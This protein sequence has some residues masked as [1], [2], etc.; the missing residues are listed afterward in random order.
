MFEFVHKHKRW[1][2][3][4]LLVLIVPPFALFGVD[5][6]FRNSDTSGALVTVGDS[7]ISDIEYSR[8][9]RQSQERMR[10]MMRDNP[11]PAMLNSP[12]FKESVLN[13]LVE[14]KVALA[15]AHGKGMS[16]SD[17]ELQKFIGAVEAF[18]DEKGQFSSERYRQLLRGQ[19]MS[20]A[21][22]EDQIRSNMLIDQVRSVYS[23]SGFVTDAVVERMYRIREQ[24]RQISQVLFSPEG[25]RA[26]VKAD[27][28]AIEKF[29][30]EQKAD[31]QI[32]ERVKVEY[33]MLSLSGL[34][35]EAVVTD[36]D[37]E[38]FYQA[39]LSR[40]QTAEERRASHIL[41]AASA[42]ASAAE[43]SAA[44][45]QAE[46]LLKQIKA[47][48]A[49]FAEL[50]G[51]FSKD[52]GSAEKGGD[53]GF[54][55]R[56]LMV[57]PF[58]DVAFSLKVGELAGPVETQY[59]YHLIR[60]DAIKPGTAEPLAKL[61]DQ[62]EVEIRKTGASRKFAEAADSF[63]NLVYE[64]FDSLQPAADALKLPV[65]K[66]DW[67]GRT[68]GNPNPLLNNDKLLAALF[69]DEVLK[70]KHNTPAVE[71]QPGIMLSARIFEHKPAEA[72][73]LD[74]VKEDI[75]QQLVEKEAAQLAEKEGRATLEKL[76]SG[77]SPKL[78][79]S[80]N[81]TVTLEK[82]QGLRPEDTEAIFGADVAKLPAYVSV[83]GPRGGLLIYR[84]AGIKDVTAVDP[85]QA[86]VLKRQLSQMVGQEQYIAVLASLRERANVQV[87]KKKLEQ[88][89]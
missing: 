87:D 21:E 49:K 57:K 31:F 37:I 11:N 5:F 89:R 79:W 24:E 77:A 70:K 54:F 16:V 28:A 20:P 25:F 81:Q 43:K 60:L 18:R 32:P 39:N 19:G 47:Q 58:D 48:P 42:S 14:Q 66:S 36:K 7:R 55:A 71:V 23:T 52:P 40:Y 8:A 45:M 53:L 29:Y 51:K 33:L 3:I 65:F 88:E 85:E 6:Y 44:K 4:I 35:Q 22:F 82:R 26:Q 41:I 64:Q 59:G 17:G 68:G 15:H 72:L 69:S 80:A 78:N 13:D 46:D 84:I 10:E 62:I 27:P 30:A 75:A 2:Q 1:L 73:P 56:G 38:A 63:G 61:K 83:P 74:Q 50:A 12:E 76:K 86:K 67:I 9:L 34:E